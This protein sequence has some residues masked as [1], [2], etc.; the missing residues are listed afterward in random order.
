MQKPSS[1]LTRELPKAI[2][3]TIERV[4][5][6]GREL[7]RPTRI[8]DGWQG[9]RWL[10]PCPYEIPA[11]GLSRNRG[12]LAA[13]GIAMWAAGW[14]DRRDRASATRLLRRAGMVPR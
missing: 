4:E 8:I 10:R 11:K 9:I 12:K 13:R 2:M 14:H 6:D 5:E 3:A 1:R 7:Y